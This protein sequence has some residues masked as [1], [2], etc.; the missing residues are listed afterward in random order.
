[1]AI[2]QK[3]PEKRKS[4]LNAT[5]NL[6]NNNGFHDAPMSK[7]AKLANV[8]PATIYIYFK[9]KQDLVD[10]LYLEVKKHFSEY[11]FE[12][13]NKNLSVE[14]GF[15]LIWHNIAKFKLE[16][17]EE[18]NFLS[19]CDN[20]PIVNQEIRNL[21]LEQLKPLKELWEQGIEEKVLKKMSL[22]AMYAFTIYPL[23]F[24]LQCH[25][26]RQCEFNSEKINEAYKSAWDSIKI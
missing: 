23:A 24:L 22:Y 19:A 14:A 8:S 3:C 1:M 9:N 4:L 10:Q 12:D 20:T 6:V 18:A 16:Q 7:I 17:V 26:K 13:Y 2:R 11:A 15:K 21:G 25:Q 5:I